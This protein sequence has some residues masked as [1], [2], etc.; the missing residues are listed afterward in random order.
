MKK[1]LF[2]LLLLTVTLVITACGGSS[3]TGEEAKS[4]VTLTFGT[5][6]SGI[7]RSGIMQEMAVDFEKE[8]GIKIDF[9]VVPDAQWR[10][11]IKA[12]LASGEAPDIFNIDV[13]P[14]S[15]PSQV[16]PEENAIDLTDEEFTTRMSEDILPSVSYNGKVYGVSYA[17]RKIWY[18]YYNKAIFEELNLEI[19]TTYEQFKDISQK[20]KDSGVTPLWQAPGSGW[21]QVL[22][23]FETGPHYEK[24]EPGLYEKLNNNELKVSDIHH[25]KTVIE[26][27]KEFAD[28]G[29]FGENFMSNTV[30]G[31]IQ[32]FGQGKAAMIYRVPGSE[33]EISDEYPEM[34]GNMGFFVMPWADNQTIGINPGGSGAMFG[35]SHTSHKEEVL[36]F[37]RWMT[38]HENIQRFFDHNDGNLTTSWPEIEPK[39]TEE[40]IEYEKGLESGTVM[41]AAVKYIDPQWMDIGK[42]LQ[43]MFAGQLT[44]D[45]I[46]EIIDKRREEQAKVQKDPA[47]Q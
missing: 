32:A 38:K 20:I 22:P 30:E 15:M 12:K 25:L 28:L 24:L 41:Q 10:D 19:P 3:S 14:I 18:I 35:N 13:D 29:Y 23:L 1:W 6:Q 31:G 42:D 39:L 34:E 36:E 37:F 46:L 47:W 33:K 9:Q 45:E 27:Q 21:Y 44:P 16:R 40:Y 2:L 4:D 26:Q 11:L 43:G 17:P 5:H 8:T 7:P